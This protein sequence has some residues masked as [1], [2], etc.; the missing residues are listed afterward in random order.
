MLE[1][2]VNANKKEK[3]L[4]AFKEIYAKN[5]NDKKK[6]YGKYKK[7]SSYRNRIFQPL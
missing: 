2:E 7:N 1:Q 5:R 4:K 6:N 3:Q